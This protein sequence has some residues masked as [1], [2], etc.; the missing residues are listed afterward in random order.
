MG[1]DNAIPRCHLSL[2]GVH[3]QYSYELSDN[4]S[5]TSKMVVIKATGAQGSVKGSVQEK[6]VAVIAIIAGIPD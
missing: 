1:H 3:L 2:N 6:Q 4:P 5:H